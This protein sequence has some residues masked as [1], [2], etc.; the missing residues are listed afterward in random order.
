MKNVTF[1]AYQTNCKLDLSFNLKEGTESKVCGTMLNELFKWYNLQR[2]VGA[3]GLK[4]SEPINLRFEV[5]GLGFD[6]GL[7]SKTLTQKLKFNKTAKSKRSFAQ[8]FMAIYTYSI[9]EAQE[10]DFEDL[11]NDLSE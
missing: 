3:K 5:N 10:V 6:T 7:V 2:L 8:K 11:L 9:A 1:Q 4:G